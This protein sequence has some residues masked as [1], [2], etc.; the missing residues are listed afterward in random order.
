M[1]ISGIEFLFF[2]QE[3]TTPSFTKMKCLQKQNF[4]FS[5]SPMGFYTLQSS[6]LDTIEKLTPFPSLKLS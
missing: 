3:K 4:L 5:K 2:S 6:S 1:V